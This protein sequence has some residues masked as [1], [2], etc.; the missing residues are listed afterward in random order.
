M[1][2]EF[3][4]SEQLPRCEYRLVG[5]GEAGRGGMF[6]KV[7]HFHPSTLKRAMGDLSENFSTANIAISVYSAKCD[8]QREKVYVSAASDDKRNQSL[9][10]LNDAFFENDHYS[11]FK[12][13]CCAE[14]SYSL[15]NFL[16]GESPSV[17]QAL[18]FLVKAG[19]FADAGAGATFLQC[20]ASDIG[21]TWGCL[22]NPRRCT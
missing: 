17:R 10:I 19:A 5:V 12:M 20:G 11:L 1:E 7:Q 15:P 14:L 4:P 21:A 6:F 8:T 9:S 13:N 16:D 3:E 18:G 2:F 22:P